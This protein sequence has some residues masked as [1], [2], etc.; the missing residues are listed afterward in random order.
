MAE[1]RMFA[2]S[3]VLSDAFL[4]MPLSARYL[5]F[6]L[7][8]I[9]QDKGILINAHST[10]GAIG[11]EEKDLQILIDNKFIKP[12][13][14]GHYLI[15]HWYE[16]N[17]IGETAKKRNNYAYRQWRDAVIKRDSEKCQL[18]GSSNKLVAHHIKPFATYPELRLDIN[19]GITLCEKCHMRLHGLEKKNVKEK[20]V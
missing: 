1:R 15:I 11:C 20:D 14:D 17:G 12:I 18:C 3:I 6:T 16:N 7:G 13:E 2:K 5:Y 4:D 10:T 8:V 9:A 19:N